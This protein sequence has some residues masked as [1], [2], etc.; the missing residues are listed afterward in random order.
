MD[1]SPSSP[2][3]PAPRGAKRR[4]MI[5]RLGF[6]G[7]SFAAL[8]TVTPIILIIVYIYNLG[9]PAIS[10]EFLTAMPRDGMRAGGI[11]P[12]IVGTLWL[13][14]GTG[15]IAVPRNP[16]HPISLRGLSETRRVPS[17]F[18]VSG[19]WARIVRGSKS[20]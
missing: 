18:V 6:V 8:L 12:A 15:L 4:R 11:F 14:L 13:T 10:T 19:R 17:L 7:I 3:K 20:L 2:R 9:V 16:R 1:P 5:Q